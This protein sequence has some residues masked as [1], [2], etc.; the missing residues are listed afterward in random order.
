ML[1]DR[2]ASRCLQPENEAIELSSRAAP[3]PAPMA[4]RLLPPWAGRPPLRWTS[5]IARPLCGRWPPSFVL[6]A[7]FLCALMPPA[8]AGEGSRKSPWYLVPNDDLGATEAFEYAML[9]INEMRQ[10]CDSFRVAPLSPRNYAPTE[11]Y[12]RDEGL[13]STYR[14]TIAARNGLAPSSIQ[15]E[16][17]RRNSFTDLSLFQ[18]TR[19]KPLPCALYSGIDDA[20]LMLSWQDEDAQ[21]AKDAAM[22]VLNKQ[23]GILCPQRPQLQFLRMLGA[24]LQPTEGY[25]FRLVLEWRE[26]SKTFHEESFPDVVSVVYALDEGVPS[27]CTVSPQVYPGRAPCDIRFVV[28]EQVGEETSATSL[29]G[30]T[31]RRRLLEE[32][33]LLK[34]AQAAQARR[35]ALNF[36]LAEKGVLRDGA[37]EA[38]H[39]GH[40]DAFQ[41]LQEARHAAGV[42]GTASRAGHGAGRRLAFGDAFGKADTDVVRPFK[43]KELDI[44]DDFDPRLERTLCF[45]RGLER[46]QG[47]CGASWAIASTTVAAVRECLWFQTI[48]QPTSGLAFFSAQEILS[49][50]AF[51]GCSG[52]D[53][54]LA[55]YYMKNTGIARETC[56]PYR[57]TCYLDDSVISVESADAQTS[58]PESPHFQ[59]STAEACPHQPDPE[60]TPCRCLPRVFHPT[61]SIA[62]P[63][64]PATCSKTKIPHYFRIAGTAEENTVPEIERDMMQELLD[65]GPLY[66]SIL[67]YEDFYDPVSW[68]ESGIYIHKRGDLVGKHAVV[69]VGWGTD[70]SSRDYWLMLNSFGSGWQQ[71]GYFKILRG[72]SSL[73]MLRFGAWGVD[74]SDPDLDRAAPAISHVQVQFSP[75]LASTWPGT[76]LASVWL[77]VCALTDEPAQAL[78]K[79]QGLSN[80][81]SG[82]ARDTHYLERHLLK[83][84]LLKIGLLGENAKIEVWAVDHAENT[85][86]WGPYTF[87]IP[88]LEQFHAAPARRLLG[89][90][91]STGV[92]D[93]LAVEVWPA[94]PAEMLV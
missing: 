33:R 31:E 71:E 3:C 48:G 19:V 80:T 22:G 6:A 21:R 1:G 5:W 53:A 26:A 83:I 25:V 68:T 58:T 69:A 72:E 23:R 37:W 30:S 89:A 42:I 84:D 63:L 20:E 56:S 61:K 67:L 27:Q 18:V 9:R 87:K 39:P 13:F 73:A 46:R 64:L 94:Q 4:G 28:D 50:D 65:A 49:C 11:V 12:L 52:G 76:L 86:S 66:V 2:L 44:P 70:G 82:E 92:N 60:T 32:V 90:D 24:S 81:I 16:V 51:E 45:P 75:E 93:S 43:D 38:L 36:T 57:M 14:L 29:E 40:E 88:T 55:F 41:S 74:W 54:G 35:R 85:A 17:A 15:A 34:S 47:S 7:S 91:L 62:C 59:A 77:M 78:V 79:V 8:L 10:D